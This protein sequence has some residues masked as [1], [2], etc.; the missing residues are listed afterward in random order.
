MYE[1]QGNNVLLRLNRR[2]QTESTAPFEFME[3]AFKDGQEMTKFVYQ[4]QQCQLKWLYILS[5]HTIDVYERVQTSLVDRNT[6]GKII[7]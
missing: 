7:G 1:V 3:S 5:S 6:K 4:S 2:L